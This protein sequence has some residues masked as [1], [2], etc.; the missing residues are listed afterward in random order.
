M[1]YLIDGNAYINVALNVIKRMLFIDKSSSEDYYM[2]DIFNEGKYVLKETSRIRFRDFCL[3]YLSSL[4]SPVY[5]ETREVH[6][7]F[8]SKSWRKEYVKSFF[9]KEDSID[10]FQYKSGRKKDEMIHLFFEYFQNTIQPHL[11]KEPGIN[12]HRINGMEGDDIIA[13]LTERNKN[14]II[15]TVDKDMIQLVKNSENYVIMIMPKMMTKTKKLFYAKANN[16]SSSD[17]FSLSG[18]DLTGGVDTIISKFEKKG[19]SKFEI[20]PK[21]SLLTKIFEGDKSDNIPRIHKMTPSKVKKMNT[22]LLEK[23]GETIFEKLDNYKQEE[24]FLQE[25][26]DKVVELNKIKDDNIISSLKS[27]IS[28]NIKLIR[29]STSLLPDSVKTTDY[30]VISSDRTYKKF[31]YTKLIEIKNNSVLI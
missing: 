19:Y 28:L 15:Y 6:I 10:D 11:E 5:S 1:V 3:T 25:C 2:E 14:T 30:E 23:Y 9:E 18:T 29:L 24:S 22:Y 21:E 16:A 8:D 27:N 12:F 4:I 26:V 13:T 7:V 17:F 31:N 20:D